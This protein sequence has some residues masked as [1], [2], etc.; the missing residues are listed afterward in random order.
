MP[1]YAGMTRIRFSGQRLIGRTLSPAHPGLPQ[2]LRILQDGEHHAGTWIL[3]I[4]AQ[5]VRLIAVVRGI[6]ARGQV[7]PRQDA[8]RSLSP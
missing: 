5:S 7:L 8:V 4:P 3:G 1:S 2:L 6:I